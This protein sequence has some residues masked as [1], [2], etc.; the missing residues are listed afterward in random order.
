MA[1][2]E[3]LSQ[4]VVNR[5]AAGE[6]VH[7]PANALKELLENALDAGATHVTVTVSQ[8][9]LKLLQ[10][11]DNGRGIQRQDLEIVCE[12][13][14]TSKL[15][16][17]ED[18]KDIKSFGFRGE[19]LASISHV[20]HVTI[21]SKTADQQCAYKASYR[22]G[23]LVAKKAGES[24]DPKPCAGKNGTQI[25][26]EDLFYNLST[27]KQALKN[28]SEQYT[29]IL[30]VVQKYAVHF[31]A[32]GVG[33]VCKKYR[34]SSCSVNTLQNFS[35]LDVIRSIYGSKIAKEL[36]SFE[37]IKDVRAAGSMDLQHQIRGYISN[38]NFHLRKSNFILFINDRLVECPA[39]KRACEYVYSLYLPKNTHPFVYLSMELPPR[40]IDVNIH[41]TKE[42]I[43]F[44]HEED[45][46]DSI[47]EAVE[48]QLKGSNESRS[49]SVRS[50]TAMLETSSANNENSSIKQRRRQSPL[51]QEAIT[52]AAEPSDEGCNKR[53]GESEDEAN[54]SVDSIEIDL[55]QKLTPPS[56]QYQS[57]LAPQRLVRTDHRSNT[58]DKYCFLESQKTQLSQL[59]QSCS[60]KHEC[61]ASPDGTGKRDDFNDRNLVAAKSLKLKKRKLSETQSRQEP[62]PE[63]GHDRRGSLEATQTPQILSSVQNLLSLVRQNKNKALGRLFREHSFVGI[64]DK[65]FS[66]VQYRTKLYIVRHD[67]IAFHV[68][69]QQVL[70][71]FGATKPITLPTPL[72][73]FDLVLEALK[74]PRNGYDKEDGPREQLADE[75]KTLL[76]ANG[77]MLFEY[78]SLDIDSQ[79]MLRTLPQLLPDHEPSIHSLPEFVFHLATKVSWEE[80]EPC[81]ESVAQVLARW[82]GEMR[83]PGNAEREALI[84]EHVLFPAMKTAAFCP[85]NELNNAQLI[86]PVACLTNL[87]KIF[88][89]GVDPDSGRST[90]STS[91]SFPDTVSA[92][93]G[94]IPPIQRNNVVRKIMLQ[95]IGEYY[96][97][98][99]VSSVQNFV[100]GVENYCASTESL[101]SLGKS[102]YT[103]P[104]LV[105]VLDEGMR[106]ILWN[107]CAVKLCG[108]A[109]KEMA[110]RNLLKEIPY[111]VPPSTAKV[112][113]DALIHC[114]RGSPV[115]SVMLDFISKEQSKITL[116]GSCTPLVG[117]PVGAG[118]LVVAH[119]L[120]HLPF[121]MV[122]KKAIAETP[123]V[124]D[125]NKGTPG[126]TLPVAVANPV[127]P[128]VQTAVAVPAP[129]SAAVAS[130]AST[131]PG[132]SEI[133]P[134]YSIECVLGQGS[135][136]QVV[137]CKHL[138][139]GEIVAI[140][141]IQNVFSDPID[142]KRILRELCIVRQL[143]HPN[144]VQIREI[145]A[146]L[147]MN[148]FKDLFVVF[149]YL[150]SDLE[151]LLHSPQFL[152]AEHLRWLLLDLLKALKYMHSA[153]IV[154]RDLKPANVLLNLSPVAIKI[155]DFGL[156]RGLSSSTSTA[157]RKRKRLGDGSTPEESILQ[158]IGVH[159]RTPARRIQRQLTEHVVT[160]WYRAPEIIF[161]DHDYSAAI[162]VWSIGCIFAELLSMQK[163]SVSSHYQ[164]EPL[165][166]G[167]SCFPLSPGAGQIALPQDSR[168]QL[169]TI[170]DVL[171]TMAEEDVAEIADPDVQFYLRSLPPRPKRN[172]QDM[173]PGAEPEAI[174]LLT[175]MLK[176]NPRKRATLDEALSH[177]YLAS[178]RSLEEEIVAPGTIQLEFDEK[179]MNVTEI[180]Q[181]MVS[182][183]RFY[184]PTAGTNTTSSSVAR[185]AQANGAI[186][187]KKAKQG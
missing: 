150:P 90:T 184:H 99:T 21:T 1:R 183:I 121:V 127:V 172:L 157:G 140:K 136:G 115:N 77:P 18:L 145:I 160:R 83:Y 14:T 182:E 71:Q 13:F 28:A 20:A 130:N 92:S 105:F 124:L 125:Q 61:G 95:T 178:I 156:A 56:K 159:P 112:L 74:N 165:F 187:K 8:G 142:A 22:D 60:Q 155:C 154:H 3:R 133:A 111:L 131:I 78:F 73:I 68:F 169:N 138:P 170:L 110:G 39:L 80:E 185:G 179:K 43:H 146:P 82:Y 25:L 23:K 55:S 41:P 58:I 181:R 5:I 16:R 122:D 48:K 9:G 106:V 79:G 120:T 173:Y 59:S 139:T 152:T 57:A 88:E 158:G 34:D 167:V 151:K 114:V 85:P 89:R 123:A 76:S 96:E 52:E 64:V 129:L 37:L 54:C 128:S 70:L 27:R 101:A 46:V 149:E 30:D 26:V 144:I 147:D 6:V 135:Y 2:I 44:L 66:L 118:M 116:L 117:N 103:S 36:T 11:Q 49:F 33:F 29:R 4:D 168:D 137:R 186:S 65:Q 98:T 51:E 113:G 175:W 87:Y 162:D 42:E 72:A 75:I 108:Y 132:W 97:D 63:D 15:K 104:A 81:F 19:A 67:E 176:M 161:R 141:K 50:I 134:N 109:R 164:R 31:K 17:F 126:E 163:S 119:D 86:T 177:K 53:E 174:D 47:S 12:R 10:I 69:Y 35:Q 166:P 100:A 7:R 38:A 148:R 40:N 62:E 180:R 94:G 102:L 24:K 93:T 153:E 91:T 84:L 143:R 107:D 45:I 32:K 171:G